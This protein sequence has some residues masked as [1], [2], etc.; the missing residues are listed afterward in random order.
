V[1]KG[2]RRGR[3]EEERREK[4]K[5]NSEYKKLP[6]TYYIL[7]TKSVKMEFQVLSAQNCRCLTL[8]S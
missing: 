8:K 3:D 7:P 5:T 4:C 2:E 1:K 6:T